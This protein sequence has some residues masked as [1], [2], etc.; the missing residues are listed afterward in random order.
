MEERVIQRV[1]QQLEEKAK[2]L[3]EELHQERDVKL[4]L[5]QLEQLKNELIENVR[6]LFELNMPGDIID[7]YVAHR[8]QIWI[9]KR[10]AVEYS[11]SPTLDMSGHAINFIGQAAPGMYKA[12]LLLVPVEALPDSN[13]YVQD[14]YNPNKVKFSS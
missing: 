5:M 4:A 11:C 3:K 8:G 1:T 9:S 2:A 10:I 12:V 14:D 7:F 6:F 13:G